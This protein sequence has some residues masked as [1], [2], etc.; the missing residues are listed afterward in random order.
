MKLSRIL[1]YSFKGG[2]G[3]T[4]TSTNLS[5]ILASEM[6]K[7]VIF[8][9]LDVESS[10]STVLFNLDDEVK[11]RKL[12]TIQ[13]VFRGFVE[14]P[15]D[16]LVHQTISVGKKD[17]EQTDWEHLHKVIYGEKNSY[18]KVVPARIILTGQDELNARDP[19]VLVRFERLLQKIEAFRDAPDIV[20]FDSASGQ[21]E[22]ALAGLLNC[23]MLVIFV[24]WTRQFITG[25][26][27]FMEHFLMS[28]KFWGRI[29][30]I[31]IVPTAVPREEPTGRI[32]EEVKNRKTQMDIKITSLNIRASQEGYGGPEWIKIL[33]PIHEC[34]ALKWDD[35]IFPL[36]KESF[37]REKDTR[38]IMDEYR[39][40]AGQLLINI[41]G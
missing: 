38:D 29:R 10:G 22:S 28:G 14:S 32:G 25:T 31:L 33:D 2:S 18:L 36:E 37:I 1:M 39:Q 9:D 27:N 17:F 23:Q 15:E 6:K 4:V 35:R 30:K 21:Q 20:V 12:W 8:I 16:S 7:K 11:G 34:T 24:R 41:E 19:D 3:R 40:L 5:Y 26:L 13:D